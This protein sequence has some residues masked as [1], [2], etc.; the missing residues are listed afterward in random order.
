MNCFES[1]CSPLD[2]LHTENRSE[3]VEMLSAG[4]FGKG[5]T[6]EPGELNTSLAS[7]AKVYHRYIS[8]I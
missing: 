6:E 8:A 1:V 7:L 3:P 5:K 2:M 4:V